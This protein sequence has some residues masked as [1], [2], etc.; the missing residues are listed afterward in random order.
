[1]NGYCRRKYTC[2]NLL[3]GSYVTEMYLIKAEQELA[4]L[5]DFNMRGDS[6]F[7]E[8]VSAKLLTV[9]D[10]LH[11]SRSILKSPRIYIFFLLEFS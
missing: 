4:I 8:S 10:V 11:F 6:K 5:I 1:M 3:G 7:H 9:S 2:H